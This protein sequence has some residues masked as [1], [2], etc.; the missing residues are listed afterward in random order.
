M[1]RSE[2]YDYLKKRM[3]AIAPNLTLMVGELVGA[4][5]LAHAGSLVSLAKYP[6]STVQLLGA[7]KALF[8]AL[9]SKGDTPKYGLIY[10]AAFVN[11]ASQMNK[12]KIA[13]TLACKTSLSAR[14]DAFVAQSEAGDTQ[15]QDVASKLWSKMQKRIH[16]VEGREVEVVSKSL[17]GQLF[18]RH[19]F[20][21]KAEA[22]HDDTA[23][24]KVTAG[25][26]RKRDNDDEEAPKKKK[27]KKDKKD[28]KKKKRRKQEE[29]E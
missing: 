15:P 17:A 25:D 16:Y 5:L 27:R 13:R 21:G 22:A 7:E 6:A 3:M 23:D 20:G 28:K 14:V 26:K 18:G 11:A 29:A 1:Y 8:R 24:F 12:A 9:K 10:H 4:R 19:E 2:L